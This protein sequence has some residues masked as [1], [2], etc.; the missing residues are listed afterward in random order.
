MGKIM[1]VSGTEK[2]VLK[3]VAGLGKA[4]QHE[5][6][7]AV[8]FSLDY[9]ELIC[10]YLIRKGCLVRFK[11]HYILTEEGERVFCPAGRVS[12]IDKESMD[13]LSS[14]LV[15]EISKQI[16]VDFKTKEMKT[17][18]RT[19]AKKRTARKNDKVVL[20]E[21]KSEK[22]QIKTDYMP[23]IEDETIGLQTNINKVEV[24]ME[25]EKKGALDESIA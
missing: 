23:L 19:P 22:I 11:R 17:D 20:P 13:K 21:H 16:S 7:K 15:K 1:I 4:S 9:I 25:K 3:A 8:G 5:I 18:R 14:R 24:K 10:N 6:S 2:E 12:L